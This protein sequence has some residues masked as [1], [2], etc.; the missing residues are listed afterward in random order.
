MQSEEIRQL[1]ARLRA[2]GELRG[3]A[4]TCQVGL[5]WRR[6]SGRRPFSGCDEDG[7]GR[8]GGRVSRC[9]NPRPVGQEKGP[10]PPLY[11]VGT[12]ECV[13]RQVVWRKSQFSAP[14]RKE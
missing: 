13:P 11:R 6:S 12:A 2:M 7:P 3:G 8:F 1:L 4:G 14:G 10:P 5:R 9:R